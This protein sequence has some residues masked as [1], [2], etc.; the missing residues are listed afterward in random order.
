MGDK[1]LGG[2]V[3]NLI[4]SSVIFVRYSSEYEVS[5][6]DRKVN[7]STQQGMGEFTL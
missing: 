7:L 1:F 5:D 4:N 3:S 2:G 6:N